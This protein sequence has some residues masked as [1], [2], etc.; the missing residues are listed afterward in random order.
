M[1]LTLAGPVAG[2]QGTQGPA[3]L[4]PTML[5]LDA[6]GSMTGADPAGGTKMDAAK[7][8]VHALVAAAPDGAPVG[9]AVYGTGTGNSDAERAQGCQDVTVLRPPGAIDKAALAT[10]VDGVVPRGYT[11]I[12]R[13]LQVAAEQ[14]PPEGPRSIVLV[15]DGEDT[16]APPEPCDVVRTLSGQGVDLVVHAVGFGVDAVGFGV[17]AVARAQLACVAQATGGTY[18]DAPDAGA[19]QRVLPRVTAT[20]LRNYQPAGTPITGTPTFD[21]APVAGPGQ[22]L[23]TIGQH[24]QR[25]YAVDVPAGATAYFSATVS[26]PRLRGIDLV[27]DFNTLQLRTYGDGGEDCHEFVSEQTSRSSDGAALTVATTWDGA[28]KDA[29]GSSPAADACKGGGRYWFAL[30]WDRVSA[31]VPERLPVELLVGVEPAVTDPGPVAV[32]PLGA[33]VEP[34]GTPRP[35]VGGGSFN[36]AGT[37]DGS[38]S[39]SDVLQR[40]EFVFYRV[41]LDWGQGLTYRVRLGETPGRGTENLS[42][43]STRVYT[44]TRE[45]IGEEFASYNGDARQLPSNTPAL[46]TVP[47][48]YGNRNADVVATRTQSVAGWYSISVQVGAPHTDTGTAAPVPIQLDL[49]VTGD[50]EPGPAY[51]FSSPEAQ[52]IGP[53]GEPGTP[54]TPPVAV[55]PGAAQGEAASTTVVSPGGWA[56]IAGGA[57]LVVALGTGLVLRSRRRAR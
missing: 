12:G 28:T 49:T 44:P 4:A 32:L 40:G 15:S 14:L 37:L 9:L 16:C 56:T 31:G 26:F 30:E 11:P 20:A 52:R 53:F 18:T 55:A 19:L 50:P 46:T 45:E 57:A 7:K 47:V 23:D 48:R 25:Y 1:L 27:S 10:A 8:A 38:G 42:P 33:F 29:T 22:H 36:V 24:E 39:Y 13:S 54:A 6:S 51:A 43:V 41:R 2:A 3:E 17:D 34:T 35:V 5:V 21:A